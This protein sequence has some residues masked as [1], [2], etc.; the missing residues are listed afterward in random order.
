MKKHLKPTLLISTFTL[1]TQAMSFLIQALIARHFGAQTSADAYWIGITFPQYLTTIVVQSLGLVF[2]PVFVQH[3]EHGDEDGAWSLAYGLLG[4]TTLLLGT[5][6]AVGYAFAPLSIR[7]SA[8]GLASESVPL[9]VHI[10][11]WSWIAV[12]P[13]A[14][15]N[16][17]ASI[18]QA[19]HAFR[20]Q[21]FVPFL[22]ACVQLGLLKLLLPIHGI[23][24]VVISSTLGLFLQGVLLLPILWEQRS[25]LLRRVWVHPG[26]REVGR[27]LYPLMISSVLV[28]WTPVV[29][30]YLASHLPQG[31]VSHLGYAF[32]ICSVLSVLIS[33]GLT[34]VVYPRFA[35]RSARQDTAGLI[36]A[37]SLSLRVLWMMV[38]PVFAIL[39]VLAVPLLSL[40]F[41]RGAFR[42]ADSLAVGHLL[43][44]YLF[45]LGASCLGNVTGRAYYAMKKTKI[46]AVIGPIEALIYAGYAAVLAHFFGVAGIAWSYVIYFNGSLVWQVLLLR[47]DLGPLGGREI[48]RSMIRVSVAGII[49]G[50]AAWW[51]AR[52]FVNPWALLVG[53]GVGGMLAYAASLEILRAPEWHLL[54]KTLSTSDPQYIPQKQNSL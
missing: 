15:A 39:A 44:I 9:A 21:A 50:A 28:R 52:W 38:V 14:W 3:F 24:A 48:L 41:E 46:L 12:L 49:A 32:R 27:L 5:F 16:I 6:C 25:L 33:V 4:W 53:G 37:L 20:W 1:L 45:S 23:F 17:L 13:T 35:A 2:L 18:Y 31:A 26:V 29:D 42:A 51:S 11:R 36:Q 47:R 10:A 7:L 19:R 22:G 8:P 34:T 43:Q 30:R 40:L 54:W